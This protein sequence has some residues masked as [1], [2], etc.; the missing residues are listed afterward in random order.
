M[1]RGTTTAL[2]VARS[3][4]AF[5]V[6]AEA[7]GRALLARRRGARTPPR[8]APFAIMGGG[9]GKEENGMGSRGGEREEKGFRASHQTPASHGAY[10]PAIAQGA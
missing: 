8:R 2:A 6:L 7:E 9:S 5:V 4:A 3:R 10:V 1:L